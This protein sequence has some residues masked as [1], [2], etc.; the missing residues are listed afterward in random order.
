MQ[1]QCKHIWTQGQAKTLTSCHNLVKTNTKT[2]VYKTIIKYIK[3]KIKTNARHPKTNK[4]LI[5]KS[6]LEPLN[7]IKSKTKS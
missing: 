4:A 6:G 2:K 5:S 7:D 3:S 1:S